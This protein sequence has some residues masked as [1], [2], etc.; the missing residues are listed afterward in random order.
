MTY[1]KPQQ[2]EKQDIEKL[3]GVRGE[4]DLIK[5]IDIRFERWLVV[6]LSELC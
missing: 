4:G 3:R 2:R 1:T 6:R 5:F